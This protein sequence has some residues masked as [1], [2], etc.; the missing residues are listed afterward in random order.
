MDGWMEIDSAP[1]MAVRRLLVGGD[2]NE[3]H[4]YL[5]FLLSFP[6]SRT[7]EF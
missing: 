5:L 4:R 1:M 2:S 7:A 6:F 3:I